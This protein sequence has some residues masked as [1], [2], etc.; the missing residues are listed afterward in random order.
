MIDQFVAIARALPPGYN[1]IQSSA[2]ILAAEAYKKLDQQPRSTP[3]LQ[4]AGRISAGIASSRPLL[5]AEVQW[6][7]AEAWASLGQTAQADKNRKALRTTLKTLTKTPADLDNAFLLELALGTYLQRGQWS[8]AEAL[9][10]SLPLPMQQGEQLFRIATAR[11]RAKQPQ[12]ATTLFNSMIAQLLKA[13]RRQDASNEAHNSNEAVTAAI[14][15]FAQAGGV[16]NATRAAQQW[17]D[18]SPALRAQ[19]W[20]AIAGEARQ[21]KRPKEASFA[22][23]QLIAA[24]KVGQQQGFGQGF[25]S[26]LDVEWSGSLYNL[27]HVQRYEPE[28]LQWIDRLNLQREAAAFLIA[29][30]L[31]KKQFD[32]AEQLIPRPMTIVG[33]NAD[34]RFEVQ[35]RWRLRVAI[36]AAK[37]GAPQQLAALAEEILPQ[38]GSSDSNALVFTQ[39]PQVTDSLQRP[40]G[41]DSPYEHPTPLRP[42]E[43][44][45]IVLP[46]LQ[47]P[48]SAT[49]LQRLETALINPIQQQLNNPAIE[50]FGQ[51]VWPQALAQYWQ[52]RQPG[53]SP[54]SLVPS[55]ARL[56]ALQVSYLQQVEPVALRAN[57][58]LNGLGYDGN[59]VGSLRVGVRPLVQLAEAAGVADQPPVARLIFEAALNANQVD[60][61]AQWRERAQLP[62]DALAR[63]WLQQAEQVR[64]GPDPQASLAWYDRVL[65]L[66][67]SQP[68]GASPIQ[69]NNGFSGLVNAY[70]FSGQ[71]NKAKQVV[72]LLGASSEAQALSLRL[73]CLAQL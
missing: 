46:L 53:A 51:F 12:A 61:M 10:R 29:E 43:I 21:Q 5:K 3:L 1:Y 28:L 52:E 35:D 40:G 4:Q 63:L 6:R 32:Q 19:A 60:I 39:L 62:P 23:E 57:R 25:G 54:Q 50:L 2:L 11:L 14:I 68:T 18:N 48:D 64:F 37:A 59:T 72:R 34:E 71:T 31:Q 55:S 69:A 42:E 7:L 36:A 65:Q 38:V 8:E 70:Q 41:S 44:A 30:A 13:P 20:L 66:M 9:A 33:L 26:L 47:Q 49:L 16:T 58:L 56:L 22:L 27:S 67:R 15:A 24:G 17:T 73:D 45:A